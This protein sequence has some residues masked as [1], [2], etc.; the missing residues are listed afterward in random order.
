MPKAS[1][2]TGKLTKN[3]SIDFEGNLG[4][5]SNRKELRL[6]LAKAGQEL[7]L[8]EFHCGGCGALLFKGLHLEKSMIE[9]KC[10]RC[11]ELNLST[12]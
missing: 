8:D 11:G 9:V 5:P 2:I 4:Y 12:L 10:R 1:C 7:D 6:I 3:S